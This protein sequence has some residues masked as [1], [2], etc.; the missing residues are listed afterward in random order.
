MPRR[1]LLG[2]LAVLI[3][4]ALGKA[5]ERESAPQFSRHI[6]AVFSRLGCNGGTCHGAVKGQNGFRLPSSLAIPPSIT[7]VCSANPAAAASIFRIP[8]PACSSQGDRA[9]QPRRRQT[10]G[11]S[12]A[13]SMKSCAAGLPPAPSVDCGRQIAAD[14]A[15]RFTGRTHRQAGRELSPQRRGHVRRRLRRGRDAGSVRLNRWTASRRRRG[16]GQVQVQAT[17][18]AALIVRFRAEPA[19]AHVL[20]PRAGKEALPDGDAEQLHRRARPRQAAAP[21]HSAR[22]RWP[23]TPTFLRRARSMLPVELPTPEEIR[24]FLDDKEPDKRAKKI[25]ELLTRPGHAALWTMKFCDLLKASDFG[26][27]ADGISQ[28]AGRPTLAAW[29]RAR[30]EENLPYDQFVERILTATSRE[31]R[32]L[33]EWAQGSA[34]DARGIRHAAQ[35]PGDVQPA[36]HARSV[37]AAAGIRRRPGHVASG[38]RVSSAC[39]WSAPSA[40]AIRTT[41]GSRTTCSASPTSSCTS[42]AGLPGRQREEVPRG[43]RHRQEAQRRGARSSESRPRRC[44]TRSLKPLDAEAEESDEGSNGKGTEADAEEVAEQEDSS[45]AMDAAQQATLPERSAGN[46]MMHAEVGQHLSRR[47]QTADKPTSPG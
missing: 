32:N 28:E 2:C 15:L 43:G 8:P 5:Q 11:R 27:Y 3:I 4:P 29:V 20:V 22:R 6:A 25:E 1:Y 10:H 17:G 44:E 47:G 37:L 9:G 19:V 12:A 41:S 40:I 36:E 14:Q 42:A 35:G 13:P 45:S 46:G 23:T 30:L 26:V 31:G 24:A 34:S 16:D 18:D 33:E 21:E 38:P 39:G 7:I